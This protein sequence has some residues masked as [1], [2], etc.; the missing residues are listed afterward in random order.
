MAGPAWWL[1]QP[2]RDQHLPATGPAFGVRAGD[3]LHLTQ[4][5]PRTGRQTVFRFLQVS[6]PSPAG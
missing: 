5:L 1:G 3:L 2:S 6:N 4:A